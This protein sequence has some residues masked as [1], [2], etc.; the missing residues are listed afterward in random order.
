[1]VNDAETT[2]RHAEA[3]QLNPVGMC[4]QQV[5]M[6]ADIPARF[7]DAATA[8]ANT[9]DRH[10]ADL[11]PPRGALAYWTGGSEGHGHIA[12]ALG[13]GKIRTT[14]GAGPGRVATRPLSW[15]QE[16]WG[17]PY[18]GWAWDVNGVTIPHEEE[19]DMTEAEWIKLRKIVSEE[20]RAL[21]Q[22]PVDKREP[23]PTTVR[24]ALRLSADHARG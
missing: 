1:M 14:D 11:D 21:L 8:W 9:E 7:P 22:A 16:E 24:Q 13:G 4:L 10:P 12:C 3:D 6:W 15:V 19:D 2:A 20:V 5:R 18:A 17:M 23:K